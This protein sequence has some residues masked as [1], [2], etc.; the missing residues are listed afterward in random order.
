M[1]TMTGA[2]VVLAAA[3]IVPAV[4]AALGQRGQQARG[5]EWTL[6]RPAG[7]PARAAARRIVAFHSEAPEWLSAVGARR[8]P[9]AVPGRRPGAGHAPR[10]GTAVRPGRAWP[11]E[12]ARRRGQPG[13]PAGRASRQAPGASRLPVLSPD[14]RAAP[15]FRVP[16]VTKGLPM[17]ATVLTI[18]AICLTLAGSAALYLLPVLIGI[19]RRVPGSRAAGG[20]QHPARL[21]A[22]R[23]GSQRCRWRCA[24]CARPRRR[25]RSSRTSRSLSP[26]RL[27]RWPARTGPDRPARRRGAPGSRRRWPSRRARTAPRQ[28][29]RSSGDP[30]V[31]S[32]RYCRLAAARQERSTPASILLWPRDL[33]YHH[34][35]DCRR[36]A[37]Q[38]GHHIR[39]PPGPAARYGRHC[40]RARWRRRG[41]WQ[42]CRDRPY[43]ARA[44]ACGR[45]AAV[46][47]TWPRGRCGQLG[48][49]RR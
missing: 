2:I 12:L 49:R 40:R 3:L 6:A 35:P 42:G 28:A 27:A 7:S 23:G 48:P 10:T 41:P 32:P 9:P 16:G 45:Y 8:I 44:R 36:H 15:G 22:P 21:D 17:I 39:R 47:V 31:P 24:R 11:D 14:D 43:P 18:D 20:R 13:L 34:D 37:S 19:G 26:I 38:A 4:A 33:S 30:R 29:P 25:C 46:A 1:T 5:R